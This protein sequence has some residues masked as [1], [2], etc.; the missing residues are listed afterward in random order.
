MRVLLAN[1]LAG[2]AGSLS[3]GLCNVPWTLGLGSLALYCT[4]RSALWEL[5]WARLG[6]RSAIYCCCSD[7]LSLLPPALG[8][9][10]LNVELL[11]LGQLLT[12]P[13]LEFADRINQVGGP[14]GGWKVVPGPVC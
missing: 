9:G 11:T 4:L 7:L 13:L 12:C 10:N 1:L 6:P 2:S 14:T 8:L 3:S 5:G